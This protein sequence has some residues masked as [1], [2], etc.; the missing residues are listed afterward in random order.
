MAAAFP[1]AQRFN[2]CVKFIRPLKAP[3]YLHMTGAPR[4]RCPALRH[5]LLLRDAW[6]ETHCQGLR[7]RRGALTFSSTSNG[8]SENL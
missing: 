8:R 1:L 3:S 6:R 2:Q 5:D 7:R 4:S